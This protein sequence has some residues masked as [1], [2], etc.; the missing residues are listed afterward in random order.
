VQQ[1][2]Y[3]CDECGRVKQETNHW[4]CVSAPAAMEGSLV[5][6]RFHPGGPKESLHLCSQECLVARVSKWANAIRSV[7][8][9]ACRRRTNGT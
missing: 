1:T 4:F 5:L 6:S 2:V 9:T 7:R 8:E 3:K